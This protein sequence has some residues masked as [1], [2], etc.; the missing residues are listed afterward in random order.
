MFILMVV[1]AVMV[2]FSFM[3]MASAGPSNVEDAG[4]VFGLII[5]IGIALFVYG[6]V[7]SWQDII[8][9]ASFQT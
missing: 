4:C 7:N 1:G 3:V 6:F 5:L 8:K 2:L 9:I